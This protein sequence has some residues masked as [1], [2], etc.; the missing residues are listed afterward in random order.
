MNTLKNIEG[1]TGTFD[2]FMTTKTVAPQ[3]HDQSYD[4]KNSQQQNQE[5]RPAMDVIY[6]GILL[7]V[8]VNF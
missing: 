3:S 1:Q 6:L 4:Q 5:S 2:T 8:A 7:P